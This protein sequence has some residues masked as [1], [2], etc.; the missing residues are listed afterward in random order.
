M[1]GVYYRLPDQ[2]EP[3]DVAFS[4]KQHCA[5]R[6]S[7]W[8]YFSYQDICWESCTAGC[9]KSR[10]LL[11]CIEDNFPVQVLEKPT[12]GE[13]LLDPVLASADKLIRGEDW[14]QS[15]LQEPHPA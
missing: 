3:V 7:W 9:K 4:Y 14:R 2:G 6:Y 10:R 15:G 1:A 12:R 8:G 5:C 13:A 11:E